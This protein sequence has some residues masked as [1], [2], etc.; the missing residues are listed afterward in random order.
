MPVVREAAAV[1][2]TEGK[3]EVTQGG[4]VVD[5]ASAHGPIRLRR[6]SKWQAAS[7]GDGAEPKS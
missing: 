4:E 5:L 1:L 6:G 7:S 3:L 2:V